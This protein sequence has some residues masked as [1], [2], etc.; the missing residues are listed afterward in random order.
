MW[1]YHWKEHAH[2]KCNVENGILIPNMDALIF[3]SEDHQRVVDLIIKLFVHLIHVVTGKFNYR[4]KSKNCVVSQKPFTF[5]VCVKLSTFIT[6]DFICISR[7]C[8]I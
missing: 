3:T 8:C 6:R 4:T 5:M 7:N 2:L 1:L